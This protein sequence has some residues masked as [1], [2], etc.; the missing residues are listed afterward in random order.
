VGRTLLSA[1]FDLGLDLDLAV[2]GGEFEI[3]INV[4]SG[5]ECPPHTKEVAPPRF[6]TE[7]FSYTLIRRKVERTGTGGASIYLSANF[8]ASSKISTNIFRVSFP[9]CV[10]WFDG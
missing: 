7:L 4:K 8:A 9:V 1:A 2:A 6:V 3:K 10:F 5:Q